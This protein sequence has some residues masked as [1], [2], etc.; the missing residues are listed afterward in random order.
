MD[1]SYSF[2]HK[3]GLEVIFV[4]K[5]GF[6]ERYAMFTT[7]YG[8]VDSFLK[9]T[10]AGGK[11]DV[12]LGI[13]HFLEHKMFEQESGNVMAEFAHMGARPNAF[14]SPTQTSYLFSCT[15]NFDKSLGLLLRY[16]QNP[17]F[18]AENVEKEKGIIGQEIDM[19]L[20]DPDSA[21]YM[22]MLKSLYINNPVKHEIVGSVAS[23]AKITPDILN[24]LY[25]TF[26]TPSNMVLVVVG[27]EAVENIE[28]IV[29][30]SI[31][32]K[33]AD[34]KSTGL[35]AYEI[36]EPLY[37]NSKSARCNMDVAIPIFMFGYKDNEFSGEPLALIKKQ[38]ELKLVQ[39]I[40]FGPGS[41]FY[42]ELYNAGLINDTFNNYYEL[43]RSYAF[44]AFGGESKD[45]EK[46][47]SKI[48][49]RI[50]EAKRGDISEK[51][52]T[53]MKNS[54]YGTFIRRFNSVEGVC[55]VYTTAH[56]EGVSVIDYFSLYD[57]INF[58]DAVARLKLYDD[59][60]AAV[61]IVE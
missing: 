48:Q 39:E 31:E 4:Q 33:W 18:T 57:R 36:E 13:A 20:D 40:L 61:S 19:Y 38:I 54:S 7:K 34:R 44:S 35:V 24:L 42:N 2:K 59:T 6:F 32:D 25:N 53:R 60:K 56:L 15:E 11:I 30:V 43:E 28:E 58:N 23:I 46:V 41:E 37:I 21:V 12:P 27:D 1:K 17:F 3:S 26:Y 16:V 49:K 45:P 50:D 47:I 8:A 52:F 14:T 10:D 22:N 29:N 9:N 51:D 55:R 5:P